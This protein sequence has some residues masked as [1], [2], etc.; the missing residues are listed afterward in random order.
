MGR[1]FI[2][3]V[4]TLVLLT[5]RCSC[6]GG[7]PG[8]VCMTTDSVKVFN[9]DNTGP[10]PVEDE[11]DTVAAEGFALRFQFAQ[12]M[13]ECRRTFSIGMTGSAYAFSCPDPALIPKDTLDSMAIVADVAFDTQHPPG[14]PLND[15]FIGRNSTDIFTQF[16][17]HSP[18]I[19]FLAKLPENDITTRF[20]VAFYYNGNKILRDTTET[21]TLKR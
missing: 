15:C 19:I 7:D 9:V 4:F 16:T 3:S 21:I 11:I 14:T 1:Y 12:T 18:G 6:C 13:L 2:I 5:S 17:Q 8:K 10:Q 20:A